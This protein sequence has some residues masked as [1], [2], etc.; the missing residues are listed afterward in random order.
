MARASTF[1][2]IPRDRIGA[3]I[4]PEGKV[5]Q[6]IEKRL[7]VELAIDSESGDVT[8]MLASGA[9]DPSQLFR[10]QEVITAIGRGFSPERAF[11]LINDEDAVLE[12]ID[13]RE[14]FGSSQAELQ[15]VKGRIIGQEGKTRRIVEELTEA[16]VSVHGH[17][18]ALIANM[19]E[20]EVAREA[21]KMLL[22]GSEHSTVYRYLHR[23][24]RDLKKKKL[25]LWEK[26]P[27]E[28][29]K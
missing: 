28:L 2:K 29:K 19:D 8:I 18:V 13:L 27:E 15:R 25:E 6:V 22:R 1:I 17:T 14:M 16:D 4:G 26:L 3:L 9:E 7:K 20:M 24:R 21:I 12:V 5:K 11:R 10:T 23:K